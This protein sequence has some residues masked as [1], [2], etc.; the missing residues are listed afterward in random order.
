MEWVSDSCLL[1]LTDCLPIIEAAAS[2]TLARLDVTQHCWLC[3]LKLLA[4]S[5]VCVCQAEA[6]QGAWAAWVWAAWVDSS[7]S[8][9]N[10]GRL[11][12]G[13]VPSLP[14]GLSRRTEL[15]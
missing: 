10:N 3:S 9:G 8:N 11:R 1:H 6:S 5:C 14:A 12:W 7:G 2:L 15:G 13:P 4:S